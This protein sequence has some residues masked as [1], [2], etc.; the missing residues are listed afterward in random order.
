MSLGSHVSLSD[1]LQ[2][3]LDRIVDFLIEDHKR[4]SPNW[5]LSGCDCDE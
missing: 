2:A 4:A 1:D 3:T 5:C